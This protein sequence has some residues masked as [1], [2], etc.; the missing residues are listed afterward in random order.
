MTFNKAALKDWKLYLASGL[1]SAWAIDQFLTAHNA[2]ST[3]LHVNPSY[4]ATGAMLIALIS[5]SL[6]GKDV[7]KSGGDT[8][9][10]S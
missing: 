5:E 8:T 7:T 6:L 9:K 2:L 3:A 1:G 10:G 4:L